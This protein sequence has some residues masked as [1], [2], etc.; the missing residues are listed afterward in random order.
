MATSAIL[1]PCEQSVMMDCIIPVQSHAD[2]DGAHNHSLTNVTRPSPC[3][4]VEA[5]E[6]DYLASDLDRK[7]VVL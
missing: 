1:M 2:A 7:I 5:W 6:C 4:E 3:M